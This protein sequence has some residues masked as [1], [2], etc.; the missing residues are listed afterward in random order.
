MRIFILKSILF[1]AILFLYFAVNIGINVYYY[2]NSEIVLNGKNVLIAGDSHTRRS[3]NPEFFN[4]AQNISQQAE[5]M[6]VTFWKLKNILE[7]N[8]PD[9]L[10][11]GF[12]PSNISALG[13][14][15]FS[16]EKWSIEMFK[17]CYTIEEF[18][19]ID[20]EVEVDY[21]GFYKTVWMETG[22][23]PTKNHFQFIG[24]YENQK[25]SNIDNWESVIKRQFY[26]NDEPIGI[27]NISIHYLDSIITA[28]I[29]H[30][31]VPILVSGPVHKNYRNNIPIETLTEYRNTIS[32][33]KKSILIIDKKEEDYPDS[34]FFDPDHLN[35]YGAEKFTKQVIK[36]LNGNTQIGI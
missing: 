20:S 29:K 14:Q 2:T 5:P 17:R 27:S 6:V 35:S 16:N 1:L 26:K 10:L 21:I 4:S 23:Y 9:T 13:D 36:D 7:S 32:K 24:N 12:S 15:K 30:E 3:L 34:L 8:K 11:L 28:C 18:E 22:F 33:Y 31:V 25:I 19:Q